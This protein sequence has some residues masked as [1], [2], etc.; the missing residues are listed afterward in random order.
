MLTADDFAGAWRVERSIEDR[1]AGQAGRF[2]GVARLAPDGAGLAYREEGR[3]ALGGAPALAASRAYLWRFGPACVEVLFPDGRPFHRF[4]PE[5]QAEGTE[6]PCGADL[7]RVHYDFRAW[8]AWSAAW[9]VRGPRKGYRTAS[10]Y[11]RA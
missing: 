5:G 8:P 4:R 10:T 9:E 2:E 11:A 3:L 1:L 7:Y 6:H